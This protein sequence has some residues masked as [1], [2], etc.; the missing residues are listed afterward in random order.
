MADIIAFPI[1]RRRAFI[2]RQATRVAELNT[3]AGERYIRQQVSCQ[4]ESMRRKGIAE[5]QIA[6]ETI[7]MEAAIRAALWVTKQDLPGGC[8]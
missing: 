1:V 7:A 3:V 6:F 8:T 2:R 4:A 5:R